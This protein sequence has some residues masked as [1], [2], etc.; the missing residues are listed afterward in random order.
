[1]VERALHAVRM[2][3]SSRRYVPVPDRNTVFTLRLIERGKPHQNA[4]IES[5][6]SRFRDKC[7]NEHGSRAWRMRRQ[8]SRRGG[9]ST[10]RSARSE[11]PAGYALQLAGTKRRITL[12]LKS[13]TLL[14]A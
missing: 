6:N 3:A 14:R 7:L 12:G 1:M 9:V 2:R 10:T 4:N 11:V 13:A 5:F 8:S